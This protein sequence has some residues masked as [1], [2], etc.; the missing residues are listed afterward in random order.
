MASSNGR[1]KKEEAE[2]FERERERG[3]VSKG[4]ANQGEM[5]GDV[6]SERKKKKEA[7]TGWRCIGR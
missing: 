4:N 5:K 2:I 6:G 7:R 3:I 1:R